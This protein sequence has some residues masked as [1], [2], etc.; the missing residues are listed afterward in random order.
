[1]NIELSSGKL[2]QSHLTLWAQLLLDWF[3]LMT[4]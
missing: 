4:N 1:V 2:V 3:V